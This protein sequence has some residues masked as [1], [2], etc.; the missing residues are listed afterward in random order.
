MGRQMF[1]QLPWQKVSF[2]EGATEV[3]HDP[4]HPFIRQPDCA[5]IP[6]THQG[7]RRRLGTMTH[8]KNIYRFIFT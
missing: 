8:S 1:M 7:G 5:E 6:L 2:I 4:R 3:L